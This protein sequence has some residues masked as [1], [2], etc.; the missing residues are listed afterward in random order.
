MDPIVGEGIYYALGS[1]KVAAQAILNGDIQSYDTL[2][3]DKYGDTLKQG[4]SFRQTLSK[5][6]QNF[7]PEIIGAMMYFRAVESHS[8]VGE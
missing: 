1:A 3:R 6:A 4:A 2:W 7:G 8:E 5:L